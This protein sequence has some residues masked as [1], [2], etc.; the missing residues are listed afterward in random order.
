MRA[1]LPLALAALPILAGCGAGEDA[2]EK[3]RR[4]ALDKREQM[5]AQAVV[6][7]FVGVWAPDP[8]GC[9]DTE[10]VVR[11][12]PN[13]ILSADLSCGMASR[14]MPTTSRMRWGEV[15]RRMAL[16]TAASPCCTG[17]SR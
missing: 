3:A 14:T 8:A 9:G 5:A 13:E 7:D 4:A 6:P 17:M 16:S 2:A 1:L 12:L 10:A 15:P 11:V